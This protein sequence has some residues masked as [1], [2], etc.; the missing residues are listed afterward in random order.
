MALVKHSYIHVR[1]GVS[2][3][4]QNGG[5]QDGGA[6]TK[7]RSEGSVI[8]R[9]RRVLQLHIVWIDEPENT[10][11]CHQ[12]E[13]HHFEGAFENERLVG[14]GVAAAAAVSSLPLTAKVAER[15]PNQSTDPLRLS[16]KL[17]GNTLT[18]WRL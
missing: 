10:K 13:P 1:V 11:C 7:E 5:L 9:P 4:R 17:E 2:R 6:I 15:T 3:V 8:G 14:R 18:A 12:T 16:L